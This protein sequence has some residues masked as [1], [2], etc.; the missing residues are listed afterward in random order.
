MLHTVA[1]AADLIQDIESVNDNIICK[2]VTETTDLGNYLY[3]DSP[4]LVAE[5]NEINQKV[6]QRQLCLLGVKADIAEDGRE[7]LRLWKINKYAMLLTDIHM[8]HIDGYQLTATIREEEAK[9]NKNQIP[10]IALTANALKD[11]AEHCK[12]IGMDDYL[13]K[14]VQLSVLKEKIKKWQNPSKIKTEKSLKNSE[15]AS[16]PEAASI[17]VNVLRELVGDDQ[18][19]IYE[20][21]SEFLTS[22]AKIEREIQLACEASD[23]EQATRAAHK[24]KSSARSVGALRLGDICQQ[25]EQAGKN[26]KTKLLKDL[27]TKFKLEMVYVNNNLIPLNETVQ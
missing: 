4:I 20:M 24:L 15:V 19:V 7:A 18:A 16:N 2:P 23:C 8:P 3:L 5:D 9:A 22:A 25:I 12:N 17:D 26:G 11:E 27:Y 13:S 1:L 6:I 10:I 14:P 21:L